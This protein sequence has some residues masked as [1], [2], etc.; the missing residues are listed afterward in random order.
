[1]QLISLSFPNEEFSSQGTSRFQASSAHF[2]ERSQV[3]AAMILFIMAL[4]SLISYKMIHHLS[5]YK[6]DI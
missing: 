3:K 1:M 6:Q 5:H 4:L 2:I